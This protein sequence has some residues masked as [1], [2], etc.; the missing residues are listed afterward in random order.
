M[1]DLEFDDA[2]D[3][4]AQEQKSQNDAA[5]NKVKVVQIPETPQELFLRNREKKKEEQLIE[6]LRANPQWATEYNGQGMTP[7]C[8]A[9]NHGCYALA[10]VMM[11]LGADPQQVSGGMGWSPMPLAATNPKMVRLLLSKGV[12]PDQKS[13]TGVY[14]LTAASDEFES[15]KALVEAGATVDPADASISPVVMAAGSFDDRILPYL[16]QH[17][18]NA[19]ASAPGQWS[20]LHQAAKHGR[21]VSAKLLIEKGAVLDQQNHEFFTPLHAAANGSHLDVAKA[22]IDA[23]AKANMEDSY[24]KIPA[25]R[26]K[27]PEMKAYLLKAAGTDRIPLPKKSKAK[28]DSTDVDGPPSAD[29]KAPKVPKIAKAKPTKPA[30]K[31]VAGK[32]SVAKTG[33]KASVASLAKK[34]AASLVDAVSAVDGL[35]KVAAKTKAAKGKTAAAAASKTAKV[36]ATKAPVKAAMP[37]KRK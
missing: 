13:L 31:A 8:T 19:T 3:A 22:L 10:E 21:L 28:K 23:G 12:S 17:G 5:D 33:A 20:A 25:E 26:C 37:V 2:I 7:L 36:K 24:G 18:A 15:V 9:I 30:A 11:E 32:A 34:A 29:S 1:S 14:G 4:L 6:I 27:D 16:I 35:K